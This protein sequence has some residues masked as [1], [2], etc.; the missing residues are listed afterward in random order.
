VTEAF[1]V[2][3]LEEETSVNFSGGFTARLFGNLSMSVDY[4]RVAIKDRVVLSGLFGTDDPFI[5]APVSTI[6]DPFPGVGAAQFFV[7]AVDTTTNG[8]DVVIDY[9]HRL[10]RGAIKLTAA[11]NFTSTTVDAVR[12]P[13]SMQERFAGIEGGA[14]RVGELFLGRYGRNRLEDLLPRQKGTLGVRWD[15]RAW[16]TGVRGNFFGSTEYHSDTQVDGVFLDESFGAEVTFDVDVGYRIGSLWWSVGA[17]NVFNNFPDEQ[18]HEDNRFNDS[19]LYSPAS[20][21]AGAPYGTAGA[22][23]YAR[24]AYTY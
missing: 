9:S 6:L 23:Y 21:P 14:D 8:A 15:Q 16:S 18:K 1:G 11:A 19:F 13:A 12:V 2:P 24:V 20:V 3:R 10:S 4:Y 7:N 5:G 17:N 22:F